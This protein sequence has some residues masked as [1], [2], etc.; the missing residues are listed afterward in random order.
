MEELIKD[1][2][3]EKN[4]NLKVIVQIDFSFKVDEEAKD[5]FDENWL[6][7][8]YDTDNEFRQQLQLDYSTFIEL[9]AIHEDAIFELENN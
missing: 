1:Q 3:Q 5:D 8:N 2:S 7:F 9:P 4:V 6:V